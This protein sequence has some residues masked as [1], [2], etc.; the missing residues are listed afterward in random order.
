MT[1]AQ[2]HLQLDFAHWGRRLNLCQSIL[3]LPQF[4]TSR[5]QRNIRNS[6]PLLCYTSSHAGINPRALSLIPQIWT[7]RYLSTA[8]MAWW[9]ANSPRSSRNGS[10][11]LR[12]SKS[13]KDL[14]LG[15]AFPKLDFSSILPA[16]NMSSAVDS[17]LSSAMDHD[18]IIL[19]PISEEHLSPPPIGPL[20]VH[21]TIQF[22]DPVIRSRYSRS[23]TSSQTFE[24]TNRIC[25]GL[26]RRIQLCSEELLTRKDSTALDQ[27][28]DGTYE[29]KAMRF[30]ITF[31]IVRRGY[32]EWAERTFRSYQ[33]QPLTVGLTK[34]IQLATHRI[35]GLFLRRYDKNFQWLDGSIV[36]HSPEAPET[37]LPSSDARL[38][39]LCVP[40]S[41]FIEATQSFEF[42]PGY[43]IQLS[44]RSRNPRRAL[45]VFKRT[46]QVESTQP[47]PLS[48]LMSEEIQWRGLEAINRALEDKKRELYN[49]MGVCQAADCPHSDDDALQIELAISNNLG[50]LH[51]VR[52]EI[53]SHFALFRD[54][55]AKDCEDFL[56]S[57][58]PSLVEARDNADSQIDKLDDFEFNVVEL[59]GRTWTVRSPLRF[60]QG[61]S[62][63]YGR[64]TI[65]A[66]L[67]RIQTGIGDVLRGNHV[68]VHITARKRGHL[69]LDKA[70]ISREK[71]G[72][73]MEIFS[74]AE[75]QRTVFISRLKTRIE[76]DIDMVFRDTCSIDDI[77]DDEED[78]IQH[79]SLGPEAGYLQARSGSYRSASPASPANSPRRSVHSNNDS[80]PASPTKR[81]L[82][83]SF[84]LGHRSVS[85]A[86]SVVSAKNLDEFR[87]VDMI[88]EGSSRRSSFSMQ[89]SPL[90]DRLLSETPTSA[91]P[92]PT[93]PQ[94][95]FS[96][97]PRTSSSS[98]RVSS[99]STLI[100]ETPSSLEEPAEIEASR[101]DSRGEAVVKAVLLD[102]KIPETDG[103]PSNCQAI[104]MTLN[105]VANITTAD[106]AR[107]VPA[108][109]LENLASDL[110]SNPLSDA[111][112]MAQEVGQSSSKREAEDK[113]REQCSDDERLIPTGESE[114]T[115]KAG[116]THQKSTM[117]A[118]QDAQEYPTA[119]LTL[120][121]ASFAANEL[122][123][124]GIDEY[125]TAPST[126]AL[127][128]GGESSP[129]HSLLAT[130]SSHL[131]PE[132]GEEP[133][134]SGAKGEDS[135][136][137]DS[138]GSSLE[139]ESPDNETGT[140]AA[141]L[142]EATTDARNH[143][144]SDSSES[145]GDSTEPATEQS[146]P[147]PEVEMDQE[148]NDNGSDDSGPGNQPF[149]SQ[150]ESP[151]S[152]NAPE[153]SDVEEILPNE[154]VPSGTKT[155]AEPTASGDIACGTNETKAPDTNAANEQETSAELPI[156]DGS[157]NFGAE[158]VGSGS[159]LADFADP[160]FP[161]QNVRSDP[162]PVSGRG[163]DDSGAM[164]ESE[165]AADGTEEENP[166]DA[167]IGLDSDANPFVLLADG[168][169]APGAVPEENS[170][171]DDPEP[172]YA[173]VA[174]R[175]RDK[176]PES[177]VDTLAF[178]S[179]LESRKD[180]YPDETFVNPTGSAVD[181]LE[182]ELVEAIGIGEHA[183][184][185]AETDTSGPEDYEAE[186]PEQTYHPKAPISAPAYC[187]PKIP[188]LSRLLSQ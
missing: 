180:R 157:Q 73:P 52:R 84:S 43:T 129:R 5:T 109:V 41:R 91:S 167:V 2:C 124:P 62:A 86:A 24:P 45:P 115:D 89:E 4:S 171:S 44:F 160:D 33:K 188:S 20:T 106:A 58:Q 163:D 26:L 132:E 22:T 134:F 49:H 183:H 57:I 97:M 17:G 105:E 3:A 50:T 172:S 66:A 18:R 152:D 88:S 34:D 139:P 111:E 46:I 31:R 148:G 82:Q 65:Q 141:G 120:H 7:S 155:P 117:D 136:R 144:Q 14:A 176:V 78:V 56:R 23:Y 143:L 149:P 128:L 85:S 138:P 32:G 63:S 182:A 40:R 61:P 83:R 178:E 76:R 159:D 142:R 110:S 123:S 68:A 70:I 145:P 169:E 53:K 130:P 29:R 55:E 99:A 36:D 122:K 12:L 184:P 54:P 113:T 186:A 37:A 94:R 38:S 153:V 6:K 25:N 161:T 147:A 177:T 28:K 162:G 137:E 181:A 187:N 107:M 151:L 59:R 135:E 119:G 121:A 104:S 165:K 13:R 140:E 166:P 154:P 126:P 19:S 39:L 102:F 30:E 146:T 133:A 98:T 90:G 1:L 21:V 168:V 10:S 51:H 8:I 96:L 35:V 80:L 173:E 60:T 118:F 185:T 125:S 175:A 42:V 9:D 170:E 158:G 15:D 179:L 150:V 27:Y 95:R 81:P 47:A 131:Q 164:V 67:D 48:L 127:S 79:L 116:N 69:I 72:R 75:E 114:A 174:Y 87:S 11:P 100:C 112:V 74:S 156:Y 101:D 108:G 71:R 77:G 103:I 92:S 64:R 93:K 16:N